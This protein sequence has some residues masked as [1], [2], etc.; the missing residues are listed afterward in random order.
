MFSL[1]LLLLVLFLVVLLQLLLDDDE[2]ENN[3]GAVVIVVVL[4]IFDFDL[5]LMIQDSGPFSHRTMFRFMEG[6]GVQCAY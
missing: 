4:N 2:E 5:T 6:Y 1:L 3:D